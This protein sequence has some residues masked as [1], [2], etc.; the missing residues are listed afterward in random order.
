V[1]VAHEGR[2]TALAEHHVRDVGVAGSNPATPTNRFK[3]LPERLSCFGNVSDNLSDRLVGA[4]FRVC[5]W[6]YQAPPFWGH[7]S[8][9]Q[10]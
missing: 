8:G 4:L 7:R 10:N 6:S 3:R 2:E 9:G 1:V 5:T